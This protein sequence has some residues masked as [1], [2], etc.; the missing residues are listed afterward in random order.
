MSLLK[1]FLLISIIS[2]SLQA[3]VDTN[4]D[5]KEM[6]LDGVDTKGNKIFDYIMANFLKK[7]VHD[8]VEK[9]K[10]ITDKIK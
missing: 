7:D 1:F 8:A 6:I 4:K 2:L 9:I 5:K 3:V 10:I